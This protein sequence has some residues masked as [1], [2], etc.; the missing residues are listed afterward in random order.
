ML[1]I[2]YC[3]TVVLCGLH[4]SVRVQYMKDISIRHRSFMEINIVLS[5]EILFLTV[6]HNIS[7][8]IA[9]L[10][11]EM[12]KLRVTAAEFVP[13]VHNWNVF[14]VNISFYQS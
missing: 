3:F 13:P 9:K 10:E 6:L 2:D 11:T 4:G 8:C 7:F 12:G 5:Y 14:P 1:G